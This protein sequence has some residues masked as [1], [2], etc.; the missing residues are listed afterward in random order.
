[1]LRVEAFTIARR[2]P[3]HGTKAAGGAL[4]IYF[5]KQEKQKDEE[6]LIVV[7]QEEMVAEFPDYSAS[8]SPGV[9]AT[10]ANCFMGDGY[11]IM[12]KSF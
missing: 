10:L 11:I 2:A 9:A 6:R 5:N 7:L 3:S 8:I 12:E 1:L 4:L